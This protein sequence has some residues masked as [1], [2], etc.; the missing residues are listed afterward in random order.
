MTLCY[1]EMKHKNAQKK[2]HNQKGLL[3]PFFYECIKIG[4]QNEN[5]FIRS[6]ENN[7]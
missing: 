5:E 2:S 4:T 6:N 7:R 3:G 1:L